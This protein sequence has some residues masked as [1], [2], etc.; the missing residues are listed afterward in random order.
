MPSAD[1]LAYRNTEPSPRP[2]WV[3]TRS[4]HWSRLH[5]PLADCWLRPLTWS[6]A[7][8]SANSLLYSLLGL[9]GQREI[10]SLSSVRPYQ[11]S[12]SHFVTP[13]GHALRFAPGQTRSHLSRPCGL[14]D[15]FTNSPSED[16]HLQD[17]VATFSNYVRF[18]G[19]HNGSASSLPSSGLRRSR[20]VR[21]HLEIKMSNYS[22]T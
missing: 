9:C 13:C 16:L 5:L 1:F 12:Q 4:F 10:A 2:P 11:F 3:I 18:P 19:T 8:T 21:R 14:L 15:G 17:E 6:A 20:A 7:L 22:S